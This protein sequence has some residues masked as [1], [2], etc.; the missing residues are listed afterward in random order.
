MSEKL[1]I[2]ENAASA[3]FGKDKGEPVAKTPV[4]ASSEG[5]FTTEGSSKGD[6]GLRRLPVANK[7]TTEAAPEAT[8]S[9]PAAPANSTQTVQAYQTLSQ[10]MAG[11][12]LEASMNLADSQNNMI[13]VLNMTAEQGKASSQAAIANQADLNTQLA[14][15]QR[16]SKRMKI[17]GWA[18]KG[19][20]VAVAGASVVASGGLAAAPVATLLMLSLTTLTV[21]KPDLLTNKVIAPIANELVKAGMPQEWANV[22]ATVLVVAVITAATA[23]A[24][25]AE[26]AAA[27]MTV[28][29]T[30]MVEGLLIGSTNP[31][32]QL[33]QAFPNA[34]KWAEILGTTTSILIAASLGITGGALLS[35]AGEASFAA[36][37]AVGV[38]GVAEGGAR[39][40]QGTW[41]IEN[42]F[43]ERDI[44]GIQANLVLDQTSI[45]NATTAGQTA[46]DM[47][48]MI[49]KS[50]ESV[51]QATYSLTS[52]AA[53][54]I[55]S[56]PAA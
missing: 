47:I 33:V 42:G 4:A 44:L 19:L 5:S 31:F 43:T 21:M 10:L 52:P 2:V 40:T 14:E 48:D 26:G 35:S 6:K 3:L 37:A 56:A 50:Q 23:G 24:G 9:T 27:K 49:A 22:F 20:V 39:V 34:P 15:Q 29:N 32:G 25:T 11:L 46:K 55:A 18:I 54:A 51:A 1:T 8:D 7:G 28:G 17:M 38:M 16:R 30:A 13:N 36:K 12:L 53:A 41:G 45:K